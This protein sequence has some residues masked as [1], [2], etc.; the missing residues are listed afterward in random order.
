[1]SKKVNVRGLKEIIDP[2][3][4]YMMPQVIVTVQRTKSVIA[5]IGEIAKS[6]DRK[7]EIIVEF[8]KKKLGVALKY[9]KDD[10]KIEIKSIHQSVVQE[11]IHEFI[12]YFVLCQSSTSCRNPETV[13][14]VKKNE[15]YIT[16]KA[17]GYSDKVKMA[18]KTVNKVYDGLIKMLG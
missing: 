6:L 10:D 13:L 11:A 9:N 14:S 15:M 17:C 18:N 12:E 5:N 16:C 2:T 4:R 3:Y 8:L 1:M 7:P